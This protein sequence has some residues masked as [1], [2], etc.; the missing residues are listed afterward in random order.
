MFRPVVGLIGAAFVWIVDARVALAES[1]TDWPAMPGKFE[2]GSGFYLSILNLLLVW[3]LMVLWVRTTDWVNQDAQRQKLPYLRWNPIVVFPFLAAFMLMWLIPFFWIGYPLLLA[4]YAV[5]LGMYVQKRNAK[6]VQSDKVMTPEHLRYLA[7]TFLRPLGIKI[8]AE[9]KT[10]AEFPPVKITA[11]GAENERDDR[12]NLLT[13]RQSPGYGRV[14]Q[15]IAD[16]TSARADAAMLDYTKEAVGVKFQIDGVWHDCDPWDR[17]NGDTV[18]SVMKTI[19]ALDAAERRE[20]QAGRFKAG[21]H[22]TEYSCQLTSQG[23]KTGE[24][25]ILK[26]AEE[27]GR[28]QTPEQLGMREK[29]RAQVLEILDADKGFFLFCGMPEG[30]LTTTIDGVVDIIERMMRDVEAVED[31]ANREHHLQNVEVT[32]YNRATGET[33]ADV[34]P[35]VIRKYPNVII[36]RDLLDAK[37]VS[38]LCEEVEDDRVVVGSVRAKEAVEALL[39]VLMLKA[40]RPAFAKAI[41][42]VLNVRLV[43]T[44]C[45]ECKEAYQP[46]AQLLA[47]LGIPAGRIESLYRPLPPPTD[48]KQE[49]CSKCGGMGYH[50]RTGIF[51][52]LVINDEMRQILAKQPKLELL[53]AAAKKA[54]MRNLQQEGIALVA[55]GITSVQELSR[56]LKQ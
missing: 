40:P 32:T 31:E 49:I 4:A 53:R 9:K 33:S 38:M 56:V 51:E 22:G 25:A 39:R 15:L 11:L 10:G 50:G 52:L 6:M 7:S 46:T 36:V 48:P 18:L 5:P 20:K 16:M 34:L 14:C 3:L 28:I 17:E 24:R 44:L 26:L 21:F 29:M 8:K 54:K 42:G 19:S 27:G 47:Q 12:V 37:T 41:R 23:T 55:Q 35:S 2:R 13:V 1:A 43:R 30:G 45:D